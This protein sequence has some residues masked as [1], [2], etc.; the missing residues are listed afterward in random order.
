MSLFTTGRKE[1]ICAYLRRGTSKETACRMARVTFTTVKEWWEKGRANV[2]DYE[3]GIVSELSDYG[4][5]WYDCEQAIGE[6][7]VEYQEKIE[8][9]ASSD[10][11]AL[12]IAFAMQ[13]RFNAEDFAK[14]PVQQTFQHE[15]KFIIER[16]DPS[17]IAIESTGVP[18]LM[19]GTD[20]DIIEAEFVPI[21]DE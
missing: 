17:V 11:R 8:R 15:V 20:D 19:G 7:R 10:V 14:K 2:S 3:A 4:Q 21:G 18:Q 5:F 16:H 9:Q 1:C 12:P 6:H 13:E